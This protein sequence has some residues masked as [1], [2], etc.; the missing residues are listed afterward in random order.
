MLLSRYRWRMNNFSNRVTVLTVLGE[1]L[2]CGEWKFLFAGESS[3]TA[4]GKSCNS[5]VNVLTFWGDV[6]H[7]SRPMWELSL[8]VCMTSGTSHCNGETYFQGWAY[9]TSEL[10]KLR[11]F[12]M[13]ERW[14][15]SQVEHLYHVMPCVKVSLEI[16]GFKLLLIGCCRP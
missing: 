1:S 7:W 8:V 4:V 15:Y 11:V 13:Y 12:S 16:V 6:F 14:D 3:L 9:V 10:C 5:W 2:Q